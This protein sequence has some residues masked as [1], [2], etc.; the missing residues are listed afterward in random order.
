MI[1][2]L[3]TFIIYLATLFPGLGQYRDTGEMVSVAKT[4]GIAH[5]PGYPLY[6]MLSKVSLILIPWGNAAYRLNILSA[7][8]G[9]AT[10]GLLYRLLRFTLSKPAALA[11]SLLFATSYLQWYLSLVSEMYTLNTMFAAAI[12]LILFYARQPDGGLAPVRLYAMAAFLFGVGLGNRMD[13]LMIGAGIPLL[14]FTDTKFF[15]IRRSALYA[16]MAVT[17]LSVFAYLAIRSA[18]LP[19]LDWNHPAELARLWGTLTRKTHG[20]TLDLVSAAYRPG[21]NFLATILFYFKHLFYGF[22]WLGL[23]VGILGIHALHKRSKTLNALLLAGW[24]FSGPV[25]IYLANIPPNPHAL[26]IL[27]AHFLLP[28]LLFFV[29]IAWGFAFIASLTSNNLAVAGALL[30]AV[31]NFAQHYP[32]LDKRANFIGYDYSKNVLR[33]LPPGSIAVMKKDV[34]L[35]SLWNRQLVEERR[36][37]VAIVSQGLAG[38]EWYQDSW[39]KQH[40]DVAL[41][42]LNNADGW[43]AFLAANPSRAVYFTRDAEY[44]S[45]AGYNEYPSGLATLV[46]AQPVGTNNSQTLLDSLYAYRGNYRY[47]A[48]REFFTP[49][50]IEDYAKARL[51]LGQHYLNSRLFDNA[52]R[53]FETALRLQPLMPIA[54]NLAAFSYFSQGGYQNAARGY[55]TAAAQYNNLLARARIYNTAPET[56]D[57]LSRELSDV[58]IAIGVCAEKSGDDNRA[59]SFYRTA[60]G[61]HPANAKA[62]FNTAVVHWKNGDWANVI[63]FLEK[64]ARIDPSSQEIAHYL[65]QARKNAGTR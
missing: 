12:L 10:A 45:V 30:L 13:L 1:S 9:A 19:L 34:Q 8:A 49:D 27:E 7:L 50:L 4:L 38:A 28:N 41:A 64:A 29:W 3:L 53:E 36:K 55:E 52:R 56:I 31:L 14:L 22:G 32:H 60:A 18:Q 65:Q 17:G 26:V 51:Q 37:D 62:W 42:A 23:P 63:Q 5:P 48:Y 20:G 47:D 39:G 25:F 59:L 54:A 57:S 58:Y 44:M 11:L 15:T 40:A 35:F 43:E 21:E 6:T 61:T 33:S 46:T 2:F 24:L 16:G